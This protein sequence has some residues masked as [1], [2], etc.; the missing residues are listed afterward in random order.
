MEVGILHKIGA[1]P[2][3]L[4]PEHVEV[5]TAEVTSSNMPVRER[6]MKH[7]EP[8]GNFILRIKDHV[9]HIWVFRLRKPG[10]EAS[11]HESLGGTRALSRGQCDNPKL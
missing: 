5:E 3:G 7:R 1:Y 10:G 4:I 11:H 8:P 2:H 9:A 6:A